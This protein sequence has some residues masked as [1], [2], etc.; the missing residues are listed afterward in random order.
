MTESFSSCEGNL[1]NNFKMEIV[2]ADLA[3]RSKKVS[4]RGKFLAIL[5]REGNPRS[6]LL[7][8]DENES[9]K[10]NELLEFINVARQV[11][12]EALL[13]VVDKY[14]DTLYY[15]VGLIDLKKG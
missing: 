14:G 12:E 10:T 3:K 1:R 15:T 2:K 9:I 7:V 13:S 6:L 11:S 5:D 8:I 4:L